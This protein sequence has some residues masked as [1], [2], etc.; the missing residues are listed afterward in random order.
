MDA[1]FPGVG[2]NLES[3]QKPHSELQK[4]DG[5]SHGPWIQGPGSRERSEAWM[6]PR[7][8][9]ALHELEIARAAASARDPEMGGMECRPRKQCDERPSQSHPSRNRP[10]GWV[11]GEAGCRTSRCGLLDTVLLGLAGSNQRIS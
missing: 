3:F 1:G 2:W 11:R 10:S 9:N 6:E 8:L 5:W 7:V 4:G